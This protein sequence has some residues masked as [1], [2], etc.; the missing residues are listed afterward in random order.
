MQTPASCRQN[1]CKMRNLFLLLFLMTLSGGSFS[2]SLFEQPGLEG[3]PS[4]S[5]LEWSGYARGSAF[6]CSALFDLSTLFG[7]MALQGKYHFGKAFLYADMRFREGLQFGDTGPTLQLKEAYAGYQSDKLDLYLGNQVVTWGRTDGFN[8]T[9]CITPTDYFFLTAE[10]DDQTLP[11]FLLRAKYHF[12]PQIYLEG[13]GIPVF[14]PSDYRY[15]LFRLEGNTRFDE[16][17]LPE[18]NFSNGTV[19]AR[20][21][22]EFPGAGFSLS[23]FNGYDPFYGFGL[24]SLDLANFMDPAIVYEPAFFRKQAAGADF[25]VP[26][27]NW[28]ARGELAWKWTKGY[29]TLMYVP[30]P[31][32]SYVLGLERSFWG[33][34]AIFQ[35]IGQYTHDFRTISE[36]NLENPLD[37]VALAA[38]IRE[39]VNYESELFNRKIFQQ[40]ERSNHALFL[41]LSRS[42]IHEALRAEVAC[43]YNITS[44][45]Y[46]ARPR[47][48]WK[49]SDALSVSAGAQFMNGPERSVFH[50]A[51]DI[52]GGAF[53]ELRVSF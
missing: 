6:G 14:R 47:L 29:D 5:R 46:M 25:A 13:I 12:T 36:P 2:Q 45:E 20:L 33:V 19:A 38:Y 35:Y 4:K 27:S 52:L 15:D 18:R 9:N 40:Q 21:N 41:S 53:A 23:Y 42:F 1:R 48:T 30:N 31:G 44:E 26:M 37:P 7:E 39:K 49:V 51:G 10:P 3:E 24:K 11:N 22:A 43:Y 50:Y 32:L 34:T 8:P 17:D 16:T 28:V